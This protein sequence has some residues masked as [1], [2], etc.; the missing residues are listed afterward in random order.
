MTVHDLE[1]GESQQTLEALTLAVTMIRVK[2]WETVAFADLGQRPSGHLKCG[3]FQ[4]VIRGE[5]KRV[6]ASVALFS[7]F[8]EEAREY[9]R[10]VP[11]RFLNHSYGIGHTE[12]QD[13][14]QR[15]LFNTGGVS[16]GG[17]SGG[18]FVIATT[19]EA[20]PIEYPLRAEVRLPKEYATEQ[21][22]FDFANFPLPE[23]KKE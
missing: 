18:T 4:L 1:L 21:V 2:S 20:E 15:T 11:L 7:E 10:R 17:I 3:P 5:E 6:L 14:K 19:G 9:E 8:Q 12:I 13:A 16:T 23:L 22:L